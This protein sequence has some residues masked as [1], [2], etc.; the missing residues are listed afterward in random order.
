MSCSKNRIQFG[1]F[2]T[3]QE[4]TDQV[5]RLLRR[6][7]IAPASI[8]EP[9]CGLGTFLASAICHFPQAKQALGVE[10]NPNYAA[11]ARSLIASLTS[12]VSREVQVSDFFATDWPVLFEPLP[13]PLLVIGN[14]PWV[15]NATLGS[16]GS[17]NLPVKSNFQGY[18]G[19]R[20]LT[21]NSNFDISEWMLLRFLEWLNGSN[22]TLAMLCK[23][24]VARKVL[25]H[26]WKKGISLRRAEIHHVDAA[27]H[28][29]ASVDACLLVCSL[30]PSGSA[31]D[32]VVYSGIGT[33]RKS[34]IFGYH[35]GM[36]VADIGAYTRTKQF[37]GVCEYRWR[38]GVKHD[39]ARVMEVTCKD[40]EPRNGL[41]DVI[42][43]EET[44]LYPMLKSSDLAYGA[45]KTPVRKMLVTQRTIGEDTS[46]IAR[47]APA[48]WAYLRTHADL[49]DRRG[50]SIYRNRPQFSVFGVGSYAFAPWKV[51]ISGFY[52]SLN[53]AKVGPHNGKS[54]MLDDTGYFLPCRTAS[55]AAFLHRLLSSEPAQEFL[56]SLVFWD[57]K[58]P[59]TTE[60]LGRLDLKS[61]A[62]QLGLE[63]A[64]QKHAKKNPWT[65]ARERGD[66]ASSAS[67][68]VLPARN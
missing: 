68:P 32:C 60:I 51:A 58:R 28:F 62:N 43:I 7:R 18:A 40:G 10:I 64:F 37:C 3:P 6:R 56:S 53:F 1:D 15:T 35:D 27:E 26:T 22:S 11:R 63:R 14:P 46:V 25:A 12:S 5:C 41:G 44:Y 34:G 47:E 50:S 2:Q 65:R 48:T 66:V 38:S 30:T 42:A 45:T 20:A 54:T 49:L 9:T 33:T 36:L 59:I 21:G 16:I 55:E 39:C 29:D 31:T 61:L 4:L 13:Q 57:A 24:S 67:H 17:S 23:T 8:V 52:K 19:L